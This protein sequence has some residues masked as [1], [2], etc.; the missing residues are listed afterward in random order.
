MLSLLTRSPR[1]KTLLVAVAGMMSLASIAL[2]WF[3]WKK[4]ETGV[5]GRRVGQDLRNEWSGLLKL[6]LDAETGQRGYVITARESFLEPF[7]S[8]RASIINSFVLLGQLDRS[9]EAKRERE[10][11]EAIVRSKL[12]ELQEVIAVRR[13]QNFDEAR[14]IVEN[15]RGK[16]DMDLIRDRVRAVLARLDKVRDAERRALDLDI[17]GGAWTSIGTGRR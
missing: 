13:L 2:S 15:E 14:R 11:I 17:T 3:R 8:A 4:V 7:E 9:P 16:K 6:M 1:A 5:S 10:E 12:E